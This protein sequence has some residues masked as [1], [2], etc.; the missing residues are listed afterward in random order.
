MSRLESEDL[1]IANIKLITASEGLLASAG[2]MTNWG[3]ILELGELIKRFFLRAIKNNYL[4]GAPGSG[5]KACH[6]GT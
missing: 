4:S 3:E 2:R 1:Y 6:C 5:S